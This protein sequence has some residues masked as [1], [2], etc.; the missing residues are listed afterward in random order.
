MGVPLRPDRD[1]VVAD[2]CSRPNTAKAGRYAYVRKQ[3]QSVV[4]GR[5]CRGNRAAAEEST[6]RDWRIR[7]DCIAKFTQLRRRRSCC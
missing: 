2:S 7:T 5:R 4:G 6:Q 1:E 3:E